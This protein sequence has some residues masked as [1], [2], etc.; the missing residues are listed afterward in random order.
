ML[1]KLEEGIRCVQVE[2]KREEE[3]VLWEVAAGGEEVNISR[4]DPFYF[5]NFFRPRYRKRGGEER[6]RNFLSA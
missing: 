4:P 5:M 1:P 2:G 6:R 3:F